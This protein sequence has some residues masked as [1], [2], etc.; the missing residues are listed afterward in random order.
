M[1]N[2]EKVNYKKILIVNLAGIGDILL[3]TPALRALQADY[4][5]AEISF[6]TTEKVYEVVK[7][8]PYLHRIYVFSLSY[9]G[10]FIFFNLLRHFYILFKLRREK[11]D[12]A[13]NMRTLVSDQGAKKIK[14]L[15]KII[16]AK[17]TLGR[18]TEGRGSFFNIK[19]PETQN[20]QKYELEYDIDTV[21]ALGVKVK[22]KTIDFI[23]EERDENNINRLLSGKE[24]SP[25]D[26]LIGIH[27]G[28]M[29]SRRWPIENFRKIIELVYKKTKCKFVITGSMPE[30]NLADRLVNE[31]PDYAISF[32]DK[33]SI[34]ELGALIKKCRVFISNDTGPMHIAAI[35]GVPLIA[36]FGPGD[37][38]R[39]DPRNISK[40][41]KVFYEKVACAPCEKVDC[42]DL[43]CMQR[44]RPEE[45]VQAIW[46]FLIANHIQV[47]QEG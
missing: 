4:P 7:D 26:L 22:D 34:K 14:F 36:L 20:G 24:L 21:G 32:I 38:T 39:F 1:D 10:K 41:V 29:P 18:N 44:I 9:G 37:I 13:I 17:K 12:L 16:N 8:L 6:L 25:D 15:F 42:D 28:G 33:L 31:F 19:I 30:K 35:L 43:K 11:F 45:V 2:Q 46:E 40:K 27:P 23:I 47:N 3:C 5:K